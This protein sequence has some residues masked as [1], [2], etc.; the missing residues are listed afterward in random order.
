[1]AKLLHDA[2]LVALV[3]ATARRRGR[4][5]RTPD[6]RAPTG[7]WRWRRRPSLLHT[8]SRTGG[9][10][11]SC[12]SPLQGHAVFHVLAAAALAAPPPLADRCRPSALTA[13]LTS[14]GED[15]EDLELAVVADRGRAA[16]GV[17][18]LVVGEGDRDGA[19]DGERAAGAAWPTSSKVI[20]LRD[21]VQRE[22]A[23]GL[24]GDL[25]AVGRDAAELDRLGEREGGGG[26]LARSP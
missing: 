11:C 4:A 3:A 10:L 24:D 14:A 8:L 17:V 19:V 25:L 6:A 26:E 5:R 1:M 2:G 7:R 21:A 20:D 9:P 16:A 23:G 18:D 22:V 12:R 13:A 15:E